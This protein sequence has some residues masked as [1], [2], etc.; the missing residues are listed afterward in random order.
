MPFLVRSNRLNPISSA[1]YSLRDTWSGEIVDL[2]KGE[3]VFG[4]VPPGTL[5]EG[6]EDERDGCND[7][8][9]TVRRI[10]ESEAHERGWSAPATRWISSAERAKRRA[11][12]SVLDM[13]LS[14][15]RC[16]CGSQRPLRQRAAVVNGRAAAEKLF[17][18]ADLD[19]GT[20]IVDAVSPHPFGPAHSE[21]VCMTKVFVRAPSHVNGHLPSPQELRKARDIAAGMIQVVDELLAAG[22]ERDTSALQDA[23]R[24]ATRALAHATE[25]LVSDYATRTHAWRLLDGES[26]KLPGQVGQTTGGLRVA[27]DLIAGVK[28][29]RDLQAKS[30][31]MKSEEAAALAEAK[32]EHDAAPAPKKKTAKKAAG[33]E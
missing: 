6:W 10:T 5:P 9:L 2:T 32:A 28:E 3:R 26:E 24:H 23:R 17:A 25:A 29:R 11:R 27:A 16:T 22:I 33:G 14:G 1:K 12:M 7:P 30:E 19:N 15:G 21:R 31:T 13:D 8:H 4:D 20:V 18:P